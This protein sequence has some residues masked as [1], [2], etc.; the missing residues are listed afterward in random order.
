[1]DELQTNGIPGLFTPKAFD[2]AYTQYH[3]HI[4]DEL[5]SSTAGTLPSFDCPQSQGIP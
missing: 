2:I 5:N 1:M 3:Q 4:I